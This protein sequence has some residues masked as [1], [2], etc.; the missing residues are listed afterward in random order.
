[1]KKLAVHH[2]HILYKGE[3][4]TVQHHTG[5]ISFKT[6]KEIVKAIPKGLKD[7]SKEIQTRLV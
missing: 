4:F 2:I 5:A 1:M 6:L 3:I 7:G